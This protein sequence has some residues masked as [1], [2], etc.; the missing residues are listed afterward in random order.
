V[1]R[2]NITSLSL[3]YAGSEREALATDGGY[4]RAGDIAAAAALTA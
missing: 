3:A 4:T 1:L 2:T